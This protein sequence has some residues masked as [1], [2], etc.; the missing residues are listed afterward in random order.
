MS[1]NER[2]ERRKD[3]DE[4]PEQFRDFKRDPKTRKFQLVTKADG[5]VPSSEDPDK[6]VCKY[7]GGF[8]KINQD[9]DAEGFAAGV[10]YMPPPDEDK[11]KVWICAPLRV[12]ARTRDSHGKAWGRL[13][14]WKDAD[15]TPHEW[16]MPDELIQ[17]D[18]GVE[19]RCELARQGLAIS[20]AKN[21]RELLPIYLNV[22]P[23]DRKVRCVERLGWAKT[24]DGMTYVLPTEVPDSS[25][26]HVVF[27]NTHAL[28]PAHSVS[29]SVTEWRDKIGWFAQGNS[30]L[31]FTIS[32]SFAGPLL[33]LAG[34]P[35]G[36]FH[37][38]GSSSIGKSI[39]L[40]V[41]ASVWGD[42]R[43]YCRTWRNTVN[44]LEAT[45]VLH[46]DGILILDELGQ[47]DPG[48]WE[49][50]HICWPTAKVKGGPTGT[51]Q[52]GRWRVG[53]CCFSAPASS[54][55]LRSWRQS[56]AARRLGRKYVW[57][58]LMPT[59]GQ[60]GASWNSCTTTRSQ[61]N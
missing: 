33:E 39:T 55:W 58:K 24:K 14:Q 16:A 52:H 1:T 59:P 32:A 61:K 40:S 23:V 25:S 37:L 54:R 19:A 49:R 41:G 10:V 20:P 34:E 51:V 45:A 7:G 43:T 30:R 3:V 46:N 28:E 36:G 21:A 22:C 31:V 57:L 27:Q 53:G 5:S 4:N 26:E 13:L 29:G 12:A 56:T 17:R 2:E 9:R 11:P 48:M 42:P 60:V 18:G 8:F 38:R 6:D 15:A 47:V 50:L 44:G 35:P